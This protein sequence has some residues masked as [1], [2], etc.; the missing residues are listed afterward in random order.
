MPHAVKRRAKDMTLA[1]FKRSLKLVLAGIFLAVYGLGFYLLGKN[2]GIGGALKVRGAST[3]DTIE[4]PLESP[5]P[6]ADTQTST[7]TASYVKLCANTVH[8]FDL[9][10]PKDW[11]TTYNT[12]DERCTF[13]APYSFIVPQD[14]SN[15]IAPIRLEVL[16][17]EDWLGNVKFYENPNEF[18]NIITSQ[19][20]EIAGRS[21]VKIEAIS[22]GQDQTPGGFAKTTYMIFDG[23]N[24]ILARYLQ[25]KEDENLE[26]NKKVLEEIVTSIR[27]F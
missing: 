10:Y 21:V 14:T 1:N 18:Q 13:F 6:F 27:Y 22:T 3:Q 25:T 20:V 2:P 24:P 5:V 7:I 11:F 8:G 23:A 17:P 4:T 19:T 16:K 9:S 26:A 12:E 15:F